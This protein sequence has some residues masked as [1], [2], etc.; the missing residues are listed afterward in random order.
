MY[1][2]KAR[3]LIILY[4][5]K[6]ELF[7]KYRNKPAFNLFRFLSL[8]PCTVRLKSVVLTWVCSL[9]YVITTLHDLGCEYCKGKLK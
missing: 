7:K 4:M 9:L 2:L 6:V 8:F 5:I 1:C 3:S